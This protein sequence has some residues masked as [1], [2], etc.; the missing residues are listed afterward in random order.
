MGI[1]Y[2]YLLPIGLMVMSVY[3]LVT[4][5]AR[6]SSVSGQ[7]VQIEIQ[8]IVLASIGILLSVIIFVLANFTKARD[9]LRR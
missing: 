8:I 3:F 4:A 7:D 6:A 2:R 1:F 5:I 9:R